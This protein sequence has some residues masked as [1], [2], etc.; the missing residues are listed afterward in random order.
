MT[1]ISRRN[2]LAAAGVGGVIA[3]LNE[4][5]TLP[6]KSSE[7]SAVRRGKIA[8]EEH[9]SIRDL[10]PNAKELTFFD[11]DTLALIDPLLP[12]LAEQ[13]LAAMDAAGI[14]LSVLSQTGPGVQGV[15]N[16]SEATELAIRSN[17][18]LWKA[19]QENPTRFRGFAAVNLL[20]VNA[21][22][23]ELK[24]CIQELGFVG[25]LINGSTKGLY[26]D[27]PGLNL[28]WQTLEELKVPLYLHPGI[29]T[30]HPASMVDELEG[31]TWEWSFDTATQALR[32]IMKNIFERHPEAKVILGHMGENLPFY[33]WRLDSRFEITRYRSNL[34]AK[35][36]DIFKKHFYITTS[37]VC[38]DAALKCSID[39]IGA[40]RIMFAT[41]Y[42][43]E[44]ID[45]AS[46]WIE[47]ANIDDKAKAQIC[48]S[49]AERILKLN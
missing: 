45:F 38:D 15:S 14:Q 46:R 43:Y 35:P 48:Y 25:V 11:P 13:R 21:A 44:D 22:C 31:A 29:P 42:P 40:N 27:D 16:R 3:A 39:S 4:S 23:Q 47:A 9:F 28:F 2:V 24:R 5:M 32:L 17:N 6:V 34:S 36:S 1:P 18:T 7:I 26:L 33:L 19:V 41:D 20:D 12:E 49:N 30:N 8:L 37:G 10:M